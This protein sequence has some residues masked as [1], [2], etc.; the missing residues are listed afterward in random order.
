MSEWRKWGGHT[1][2]STLHADHWVLLRC[3]GLPPAPV[4]G[5]TEESWVALVVKWQVIDRQSTHNS[6]RITAYRCEVCVGYVH[7]LQRQCP[8]KP[9]SIPPD[10]QRTGCVGTRVIQSTMP[11][12]LLQCAITSG[13]E[14]KQ[15][16]KSIGAFLHGAGTAPSTTLAFP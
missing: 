12:A 9:S 5:N 8:P 4:C 16:T 2:S 14:W 1:T 7:A 11:G 6:K 3:D 15:V 13:A 10:L